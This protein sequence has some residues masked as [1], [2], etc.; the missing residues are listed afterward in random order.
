MLGGERD[1]VRLVVA[2]VSHTRTW[3]KEGWGEFSL[4]R[5]DS[6]IH[7]TDHIDD[8]RPMLFLSVFSIS[9]DFPLIVLL[10]FMNLRL[11]LLFYRFFLLHCFRYFANFTENR[12]YF[13]LPD[14]YEIPKQKCSL[15]LYWKVS[16]SSFVVCFLLLSFTL[17]IP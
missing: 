14:R 16:C 15:W 13:R 6:L 17:S 11:N 4:R 9:L 10:L 12:L 2:N 1:R 8:K 7:W 3:T 5:G